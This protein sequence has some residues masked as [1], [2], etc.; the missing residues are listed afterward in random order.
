VL[1]GEYQGDLVVE[2]HRHFI[3]GGSYDALYV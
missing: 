1:G 3:Q 2:Q